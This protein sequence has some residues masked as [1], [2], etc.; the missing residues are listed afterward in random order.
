MYEALLQSHTTT[1][2]TAQQIF[3]MGKEEVNRIRHNM[4]SI[5]KRMGYNGKNLREFA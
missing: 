5:M 1:N 2:Y 4:E 3:D